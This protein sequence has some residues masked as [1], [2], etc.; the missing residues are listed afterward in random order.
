[1]Q[2]QRQPP[3][4]ATPS[5][6]SVADA[7]DAMTGVVAPLLAGFTITLTG[8]VVQ[9]S[10]RLRW[11]SVSVLGLTIGAISLITTLQAGFWIRF[12]RRQYMSGSTQ[13]RKAYHFW[14][15]VARYTYGAGISL[16]FLGLGAVLAPEDGQDALRWL[17]ASAAFIA[18]VGEIV[19]AIYSEIRSSYLQ[20]PSA[21]GR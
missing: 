3:P 11:P 10:E 16:L 9:E 4:A 6:P 1:M 8:L 18:A 13:A 17:A 14:N 20:G 15:R 21:Q 2:G 12:Y 5:G 7:T 19:G